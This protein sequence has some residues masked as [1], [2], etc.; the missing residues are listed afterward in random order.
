LGHANPNVTA[1]IYLHALPDDD[2][3]GPT[4]GTPLLADLLTT[5]FCAVPQA[6]I[7]TMGLPGRIKSCR[8]GAKSMDYVIDLDPTH[9][10][11]A[12]YH[13]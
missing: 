3:R 4:R 5:F 13:W 9:L 12:R 8:E 1:R 11:S 2:Q 7:C 6:K 10:N